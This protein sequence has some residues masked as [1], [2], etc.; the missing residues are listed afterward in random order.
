MGVKISYAI[1]VCNELDEIKRLLPFLKENKRI[2]DEIVILFDGNK[3]TQEVLDYLLKFNKCPNVQTWRSNFDGHFGNWKNKL[4][5]Y[6]KGD[7]IFQID[8]DEQVTKD[9]IDFIPLLVDKN[10]EVDVFLVSRIN[11]VDGL[12]EEHIK[13]WGWSISKLESHIEEKEFD[14]D[15]PE[16]LGEYNLLKNHNLVIEES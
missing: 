13:K 11:T 10:P 3:G 16:D 8:A 14:L 9:M 5:S 2:D 6:C 4:T 12:T 7:I 15:N 1:T